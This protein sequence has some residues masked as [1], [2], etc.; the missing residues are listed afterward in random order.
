MFFLLWQ[1]EIYSLP[2]SQPVLSFLWCQIFL[3]SHHFHG[4]MSDEELM[5]M[6]YFLNEDELF[7]DE[8]GVEGFYIF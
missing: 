3:G 8:A 6:D 7:D 4:S 2:L 1:V 5:D